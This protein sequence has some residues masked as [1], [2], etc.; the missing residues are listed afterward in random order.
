MATKKSD[1][2][3]E[4]R[5]AL[6]DQLVNIL[7]LDSQRSFILFELDHNP[8]RQQEIMALV[9]EIK[10]YYSHGLIGGIKDMEKMVDILIALL[11][12]YSE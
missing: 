1:K 4:E 8:E 11:K 5:K 12:E 3:K 7:N 6:V 10:K 2:F 9:P